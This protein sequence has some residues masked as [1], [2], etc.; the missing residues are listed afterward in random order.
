MPYKDRE[1]YSEQTIQR[2][3]YEHFKDMDYKMSNVYMFGGSPGWESD[4]F[5]M[6]K[7]RQTWE[8]EI[9]VDRQDFDRDFQLKPKKHRL[10]QKAFD[11]EDPGKL[12][13]PNVYCFCS[14]EGII[15]E[16]RVPEYAGLMEVTEDY[17][18]KYTVKVPKIHTETENIDSTLLKK[19][20]NKSLRL[21]KLL[22]EFRIQ[23]FEH[24]DQQD[25]IVNKFLKTI[26]M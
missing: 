7:S 1:N 16:D 18:I 20:Y 4:F 9:K 21:E 8:I 17:K 10:F 23:L 3:L 6:T 13:L 12:F 2:L 14:P 24:P 15:P 11:D 22:A 5:F 19:F 26:R 25:E